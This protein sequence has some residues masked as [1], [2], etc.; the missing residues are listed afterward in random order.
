[1]NFS[2]LSSAD[3]VKAS[4]MVGLTV[5]LVFFIVHT[6]L[7]AVGPRKPAASSKPAA[8]AAAPADLP[9]VAQVSEADAAA[10]QA[11]AGTGKPGDGT[12]LGLAIHDP[13]VP[14]HDPEEGKAPSQP[15]RKAAAPSAEPSVTLRATPPL[16]GFGGMRAAGGSPLAGLF[17]A[18]RGGALATAPVAP[19]PEPEIR[20]VG[21]VHGDPSVAT[22][23]VG[24]RVLVFRAGEGISP[25]YRL[26]AVNEEGVSVQRKGGPAAMRVGEVWNPAGKEAARE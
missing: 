6:L 25:G 16:P 4:A 15:V 17:G 1:M 13:F 21:V 3:R 10:R 20:L 12:A 19:P 8:A 11:A 2:N 26:L 5:V 23:S 14:I 22:I 24:G 7:A 18:P 9:G